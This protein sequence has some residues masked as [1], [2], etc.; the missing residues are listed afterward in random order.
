[1]NEDSEYIRTMDAVTVFDNMLH[2]SRLIYNDSVNK[3]NYEIRMFP[4]S[5]TAMIFGFRQKEYLMEQAGKT[6]M[7][8]MN[9][10]QDSNTKYGGN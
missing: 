8:A 3:L 1:M 5:L 7:T 6:G 4:V 9:A 10:C 2:T